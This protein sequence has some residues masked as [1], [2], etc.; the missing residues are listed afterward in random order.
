M[1]LKIVP[2][3]HGRE[4]AITGVCVW[5]EDRISFQTASIIEFTSDVWMHM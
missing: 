3:E 1:L 5:H 4:Q 2:S